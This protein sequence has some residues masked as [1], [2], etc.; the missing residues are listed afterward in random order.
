VAQRAAILPQPLLERIRFHRSRLSVVSGSKPTHTESIRAPTP[1]HPGRSDEE[2]R[3]KPTKER[4][5]DTNKQKKNRVFAGRTRKLLALAVAGVLTMGI[6]VAYAA[7][8]A[9]GSGIGYAKAS[10][11]QGL[12]TLD[13]SAT[14]AATLYPGATGDVK[15][16]IDNPNPYPVRITAV[17]GAGTITSDKGSACDSS[18]GV[19]FTNQTA[20]TLDVPASSSGTFTLAGA[21][22]MSNASDNSCQGAVFSIP[23]SLSGGSNA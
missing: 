4:N 6:G 14:T 7:W 15:L 5:V 10:S 13:T 21:V 2:S 3:G 19:S 17:S 18:T 9:S 16:K 1:L 23:V 11:A 8:T 12:G 22:A 20:L